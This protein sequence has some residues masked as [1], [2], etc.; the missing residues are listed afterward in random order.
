VADQDAL[1]D[2]LGGWLV[3]PAARKSV[4]DAAAAT[5]EKLGGALDR[6][7]AALEPYLMQLRLEQ[8]VS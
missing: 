8:R 2:C 3:N 6:T 5:I 4:A 7:I 1:T